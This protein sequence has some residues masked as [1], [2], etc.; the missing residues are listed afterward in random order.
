MIDNG[1]FFKIKIRY[2]DIYPASILNLAKKLDV[3]PKLIAESK[4]SNKEVFAYQLL[5][6]DE[7]RMVERITQIP[8]SPNESLIEFMD[9]THMVAYYRYDK[10]GRDIISFLKI[11]PSVEFW[12]MS[13]P[14]IFLEL[15]QDKQEDDDL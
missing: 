5:R 3:D 6:R 4:K 12:E 14:P 9:G 8:D 2:A 15:Q 13:P 7:I 1:D 10:L 11:P